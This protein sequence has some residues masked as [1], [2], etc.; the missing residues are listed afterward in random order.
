WI[1]QNFFVSWAG[2]LNGSLLFALVT[3]LLWWAV[4]VLMYR[5]RWF[6]KV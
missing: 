2:A 4:G 1:Y 5:Q 3:V 6:L